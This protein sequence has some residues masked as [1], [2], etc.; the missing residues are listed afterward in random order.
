LPGAH[1]AVHA[2]LGAVGGLWREFER[3][4][5]NTLF[6]SA[7][8]LEAWQKHIGTREQWSPAIVVIENDR[9]VQAILPL[10]IQR[11]GVAHRLSW[12]GQELCDYLAPLMS[13]EFIR[14]EPDRFR[15]L[16]REIGKLMQSDPRFR[17]DWVE[18]RRMPARVGTHRN[19]AAALDS[20]RHPSPSHIATLPAD[21]DRYYRE[22]RTSKARKQDRSKLARLSELGDVSLYEPREPSEIAR[23]LETLFEQKADALRRKGIADLF[24]LPGRRDF[25]LD[26]A[27][28]PRLR[29]T[30]HVS[31]LSV[32]TS[33]AAIALGMEYKGRYSLF[34]VSYDRTFARLSPGVIHLNKLLERALGRG[35]G[36][37]DFLVGEQRLKLEWTDSEIE[38]LDHIAARRCAALCPRSRRACS[39][40]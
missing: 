30:V 39:P 17:H 40:T 25:F 24:E 15:A 28:S 31:A 21:W 27:S 13:E 7:G 33:L 32:G 6:Q 22:H 9:G 4:A 34:M 2:D 11:Q 1:I 14:I 19:P 18:F 38:L 12:L 3:R 20:V 16:W 23:T 5:V 36:E 26:L 35:L 29:D 37:F 8:Y 10:A